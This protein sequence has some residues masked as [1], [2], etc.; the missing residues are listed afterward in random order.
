MRR[1]VRQGVR[2]LV[3]LLRALRTDQRQRQRGRTRLRWATAAV[4]RLN[5]QELPHSVGA[6]RP[7]ASAYYC[8]A[9]TR[10]CCAYTGMHARTR[11]G[12]H[13]SAHTRRVGG[14]G[15]AQETRTAGRICPSALP[16]GFSSDATTCEIRPTVKAEMHLSAVQLARAFT[17][18]D[19]LLVTA[20]KPMPYCRR[21]RRVRV[22]A[23]ARACARARGRGGRGARDRYRRQVA[24]GHCEPLT[25]APQGCAGVLG[26]AAPRY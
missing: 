12:T 17:P 4:T 11:I 1:A 14:Y 2:A 18:S 10:T 24:L 3:A 8:C 6:L 16:I 20:P 15:V 22:R 26:R 5:E 7:D 13:A 23:C 25:C 21:R 19:Q 9:R